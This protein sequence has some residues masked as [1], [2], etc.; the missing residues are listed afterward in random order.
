MKKTIFLATAIAVLTFTSCSK[1]TPQPETGNSTNSTTASNQSFKYS[2]TFR[3]YDATKEFFVDVTVKSNNKNVFDL[4]CESTKKS[5]MVL[6]YSK[7]S[8]SVQ[9]PQLQTQ[10][11]NDEISNRPDPL[12]QLYSENNVAI[13]FGVPNKGKAIGFT[14]K[15]ALPSINEKTSTYVSGFNGI[16]YFP[17]W[18]NSYSVNNYTGG[19]GFGGDDYYESG[20]SWVHYSY[21][22]IYGFWIFSGPGY[23]NRMCQLT[24]SGWIYADI[25]IYS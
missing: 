20:G 14:L 17:G 13:Y 19:L 22:F 8:N 3:V 6:L 11:A 9:A 7:P 10:L 18:C 12:N 1:K 4:N 5:E 21:Q 15:H 2:E 23:T 25:N 16:T 24:R